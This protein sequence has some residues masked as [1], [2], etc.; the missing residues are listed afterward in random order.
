MKINNNDVIE[1]KEGF[2]EYIID[3]NENISININAY[4]S[5]LDFINPIFSP[6]K[7]T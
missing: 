5:S 7:Y 4:N 6:P 3:T 2:N 1:I